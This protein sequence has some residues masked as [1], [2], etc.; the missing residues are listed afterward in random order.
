M[1]SHLLPAIL[2][3]AVMVV[4]GAWVADL[5]PLIIT[6]ICVGVVILC[7]M[8]TQKPTRRTNRKSLADI[9]DPYV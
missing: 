3:I 5:Y 8:S 1:P 7:Y 2:T 4:I 9:D 6:G